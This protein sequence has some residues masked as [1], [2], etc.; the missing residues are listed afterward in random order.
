MNARQEF[1]NKADI[2][3]TFCTKL[4]TC[5]NTQTHYNEIP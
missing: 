3:N 2:L 5:L 4:L 1:P